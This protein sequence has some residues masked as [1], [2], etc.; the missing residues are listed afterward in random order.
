V[1]HI[2]NETEEEAAFICFGGHEGYVGRDGIS[3]QQPAP[4]GG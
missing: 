4:L 2:R 1:R 3:E